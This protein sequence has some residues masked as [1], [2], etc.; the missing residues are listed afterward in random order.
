MDQFFQELNE[1]TDQKSM[2][3]FE[4]GSDCKSL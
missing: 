1:G 3:H 4:V 2:I